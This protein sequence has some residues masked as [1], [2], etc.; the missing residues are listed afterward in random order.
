MSS[1]A[2]WRGHACGQFAVGSFLRHLE[3]NRV[4]VINGSKPYNIEISK[5]SQIDL[6][7]RCGVQYPRSRAVNSRSLL[8]KAAEGLRYPVLVKPNCGGAGSGIRKFDSP[9]QLADGA[10]QVELGVDHIA[11]VQE[12]IPALGDSIV[13]IEVLDRA[14]LYAIRIT[15]PASAFNL[16][17]A[18]ICQSK[19]QLKVEPYYPPESVVNLALNIARAASLDLGGI[20]YL[21]DP[22][23]G[24]PVFYDVNALSNF[25]A[26]AREMLG[27][28]PTERLVDF[29]QRR[30]Q[31][32]GCVRT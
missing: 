21:I 19:V 2:A 6:F 18:D 5:L 32:I 15:R 14:F 3:E 27:F 20:E 7:R 9:Q 23:S 16:C 12:C 22:R 13:R 1:S 4:E 25:V 8:V 17:P 31:A 29:L 26:G 11:L 30:L 10:A 24:E 28:C